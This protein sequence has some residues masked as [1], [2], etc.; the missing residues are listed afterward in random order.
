LSSIND[1]AVVKNS[2]GSPKREVTVGRYLIT[3]DGIFLDDS[4]Y[5]GR[6]SVYTIVDTKTGKESVGISGVG[7]TELSSHMD[8]KV[9]NTHEQ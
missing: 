2:E 8:G 4:A 1:V 3:R 6:R 7:I 9:S 5:N